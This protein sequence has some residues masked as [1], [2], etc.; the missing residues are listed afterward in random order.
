MRYVGFHPVNRE[1]SDKELTVSTLC[2]VVSELN[3]GF[4][5]FPSPFWVSSCKQGSRHKV[6]VV[7]GKFKEDF[8]GFPSPFNKDINVGKWFNEQEKERWPCVAVDDVEGLLGGAS[9]V[10]P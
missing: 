8:T 10:H 7:I 2:C 4:A 9:C 6:P 1:H 3:E 5:G